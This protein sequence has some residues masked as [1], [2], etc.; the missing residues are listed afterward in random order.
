MTR[1][2]R[3]IRTLW[4]KWNQAAQKKS[5]AHMNRQVND[6]V[7]FINW[8]YE[9]DPPMAI[10][11]DAA[12]EPNRYSIQ[13]YHSTATQA[14]ELV[15]KQV[16]EVGCGRGGGASYLTRA[17]KPAAYVGLDLS[18]PGVEFCS[19]RHR[20]AGLEFVEGDAQDLPFPEASFDAV[21]NI[22]SSHFYPN[23]NQFLGEVRRVLRPGGA[24]L[25]ADVRH[26][27]QLDDWD[28]ALNASG[29]QVRSSR[30]I[31]AEVLRGMELNKTWD[32]LVPKL[33]QP[34]AAPVEG[35]VLYRDVKKKKQ[36]YRIYCLVKESA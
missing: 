9:E 23:F 32:G 5:Y 17:L 35:G 29:M 13:L 36:V 6:D 21:I 27:F 16:L 28:A 30:D 11:L 18:A 19:R 33:L 25:Y 31:G 20:V 3:A 26:W 12:D 24:F 7:L 15:G 4:W 2:D 34:V 1:T 14:G 22:E 8:G 10:P